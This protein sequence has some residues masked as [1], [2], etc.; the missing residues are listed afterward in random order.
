M[1][2]SASLGT[3]DRITTPLVWRGRADA[4]A[5][6]HVRLI[7][8]AAPNLRSA[9][10]TRLII[11]EMVDWRSGK[12]GLQVDGRRSSGGGEFYVDTGECAVSSAHR[13]LCLILGADAF[14]RLRRGNVGG[15]SSTLRISSWPPAWI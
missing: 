9:P 4:C 8:A 7:P 2:R 5:I 10:R 1:R 6:A 3:F 15:G 13:A 14:L 11:D 12:S